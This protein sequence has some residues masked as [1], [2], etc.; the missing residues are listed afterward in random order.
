VAAQ[1]TELRAQTELAKA[2]ADLDR[3]AGRILKVNNV[4]LRDAPSVQK[5]VN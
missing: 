2:T 3:A 5:G 4:V 1:S